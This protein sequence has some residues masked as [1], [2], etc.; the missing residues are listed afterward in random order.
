[1]STPEMSLRPLVWAIRR[2]L[3]SLDGAKSNS[4]DLAHEIDEEIR[5]GHDY[6]SYDFDGKEIV[7][8]DYVVALFIVDKLN[9]LENGF[10]VYDFVDDMAGLTEFSP[11]LTPFYPYTPVDESLYSSDPKVMIDRLKAQASAF[12]ESGKLQRD[13]LV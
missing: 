3:I 4:P 1:M 13:G 12:L 8:R 9:N 11:L 5:N 6:T 10:N 7:E 2:E